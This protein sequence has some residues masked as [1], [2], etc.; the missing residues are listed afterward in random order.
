ML[1]QTTSLVSATRSDPVPVAVSIPC[2]AQQLPP[3]QRQDLALQVLAGSLRVAHLARRH[4]VSRKFPCRQAD[5]ARLA[6]E[7]AF[8]LPRPTEPVLFHQP[9]TRSWLR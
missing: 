7:Q 6:L 5:T 9:V 1:G 4:Q 3:Q 8:D 2:P